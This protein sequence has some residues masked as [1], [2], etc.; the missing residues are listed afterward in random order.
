MI[1]AMIT[2]IRRGACVGEIASNKGY[3]DM[4]QFSETLDPVKYRELVDF[5][6]TGVSTNPKLVA[7]QASI[8]ASETKTKSL[9]ALFLHLSVSMSSLDGEIMASA[10]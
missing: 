6:R 7:T 2:L 1:G 5:F 3:N 9:R 8:A 4:G 10:E